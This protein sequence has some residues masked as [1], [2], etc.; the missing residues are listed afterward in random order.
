MR[1]KRPLVLTRKVLNVLIILNLI[2]AAG[3]VTIF[4]ASFAIPETLFTALGVRRAAAGSDRLIAGMRLLMIVGLFG[5]PLRHAI[6]Q[7]LRTMTG[8]VETGDP[9]VVDNARRLNA[10]AWCVLGL[11]ILHLVVGAIAASSSSSVQPLDIN[12]TFS[13]T[14]LLTVLLLFVLARVFDEGARMRADLEGTV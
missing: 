6:L 11:E 3:I 9:F 4:V 7:L 13:V 5:V 8:T 12:W 2:Y 14:P 10:I 1:S